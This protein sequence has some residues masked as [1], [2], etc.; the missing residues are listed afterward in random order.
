MH[1]V[2]EPSP[3]RIPKFKGVNVC[4]Q[5]MNYIQLRTKMIRRVERMGKA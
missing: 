1:K 5:G 4:M 3:K 2:K